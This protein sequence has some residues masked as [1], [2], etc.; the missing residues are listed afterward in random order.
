MRGFSLKGKW[1]QGYFKNENP[2]TVELGCGKGEYTVGLSKMYPERNFIGIDIKGARMWRGCK[3]VAEEG[4][5]NVAFIRTKIEL[6]EHF[7]NP[8]E[9]DEV[10]LT[11]PDPRP[12]RIERKKRLS[13]PEFLKRYSGLLKEGGIIHL[14][15]DN[16]KLFDYTLEVIKET[17]QELMYSTTDL[18]ESGYTGPASAFRTF[19]EQMFLKE[20]IKI[21][22]L[23]FKFRK[24]NG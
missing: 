5:K 12:K 16:R 24:L 14:K 9:V 22:Y 1:H 20:N 10:W 19:Y 6:V 7:F 17:G 21:N 18:Y 13:S 3:T 11:F 2:I 4:L 23:Q 8:G 15:T